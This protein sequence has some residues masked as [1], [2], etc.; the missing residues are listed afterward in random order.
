MS[1]M[2]SGRWRFLEARKVDV[3]AR[4][5]PFRHEI[6]ELRRVKTSTT[7]IMTGTLQSWHYTRATRFGQ[8]WDMSRHCNGRFDW[9]LICVVS[10]NRYFFWEDTARSRI[11]DGSI[12][13]F[14]SSIDHFGWS[15]PES[16]SFPGQ[17]EVPISM[18]VPPVI[19]YLFRGL[20]TIKIKKPSSDM[21]VPL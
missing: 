18:G 8:V 21:G 15:N 1:S 20:S 9:M 2:C 17:M 16:Q 4:N 5:I 3:E 11:F 7:P 14:A 19:I 10:S 6:M 13:M 12:T